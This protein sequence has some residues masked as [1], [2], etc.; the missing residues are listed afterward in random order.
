MSSGTVLLELN[1][2]GM[3]GRSYCIEM[4]AVQ[5]SKDVDITRSIQGHG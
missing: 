3:E 2:L 4:Y 1:N 5:Q